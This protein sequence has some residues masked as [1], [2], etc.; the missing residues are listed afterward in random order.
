MGK[1]GLAHFHQTD[2]RHLRLQAR[3]CFGFRLRGGGDG[4]I[5]VKRVRHNGF[6]KRM[7]GVLLHGGGGLKQRIFA[8]IRCSP[9]GGDVGLALG[10]RACFVQHHGVNM[11][12]LLHGGGVF[13]PHAM[14][15]GNAHAC[16][17]CGGRCQ[18][19]RTWASHHQHGNGVHKGFG[20]TGC[21]SPSGDKG[22]RGDG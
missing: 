16:H 14:A 7:G 6:G 3:A 5:A 10:E 17:N 8:D 2:A 9:D 22:E 1:I 18:T 19:Q 15:H 21:D 11:P 12:C 20:C 4:K 13:E